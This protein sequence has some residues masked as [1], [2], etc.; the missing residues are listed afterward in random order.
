MSAWTRETGKRVCISSSCA[1]DIWDY[2]LASPPNLINITVNGKPIRAVAQVTK[3]AYLFV[4]DR[5]NGTPVWP[6]EA[7]RVEAGTV[8]EEWYAPTQPHPTR[9]APYD[10]QGVSE[11]DLIDFTPELN[12]EARAMLKEYKIRPVFTRL[13]SPTRRVRERCRFRPHRAPRCGKVRHG[14][15]KPTCCMCRR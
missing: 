1:H 15:P 14:I 7:R 8:P 3:W 11:Q 4:F 5:V 2:D 9:P 13:S 12:A 10:R 6:I